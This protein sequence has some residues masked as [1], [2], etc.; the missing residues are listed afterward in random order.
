MSL[1]QAQDSTSPTTVERKRRAA[2]CASMFWCDDETR[3]GKAAKQL[4]KSVALK[5]PG[6]GSYKVEAKFGQ[7]GPK[8]LLIARKTIDLEDN[9]PGPG[10]YEPL[11]RPSTSPSV[12]MRPPTVH[13]LPVSVPGP[14]DY[15]PKVPHKRAPSAQ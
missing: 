4:N 13:V 12:K 7:G 14:A 2:R 10:A 9:L 5:A 6:P 1:C 11:A 15:S 8:A 3:F